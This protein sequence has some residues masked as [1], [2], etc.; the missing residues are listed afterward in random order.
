MLT[1][2]LEDQDFALKQRATDA[3]T[4]AFSEIPKTHG[5]ELLRAGSMSLLAVVCQATEE[6]MGVAETADSGLERSEAIG[7]GEMRE[8]VQAI[9]RLGLVDGV[10]DAER[11]TSDNFDEE[12]ADRAIARWEWLVSELG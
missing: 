5:V 8:L 7:P 4:T 9:G 12:T 11:R 3:L 2:W 1:D 6:L 10:L